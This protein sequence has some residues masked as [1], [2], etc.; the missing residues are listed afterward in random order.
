MRGYFCVSCFYPKNTDHLFKR[1]PCILYG[2][3]TVT[4]LYIVTLIWYSCHITAYARTSSPCL[5]NFGQLNFITTSTYSLLP[6]VTSLGGLMAGSHPRNIANSDALRAHLT[7]C[8]LRIFRV[9][10]SWPIILSMHNFPDAEINSAEM[11]G[12]FS[13]NVFE[14]DGGCCDKFEAFWRSRNKYLV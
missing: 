12:K 14:N 7:M 6:R 10:P 5:G 8:D 3:Y 9:C 1:T 4:S 13:A 2:P 11:L